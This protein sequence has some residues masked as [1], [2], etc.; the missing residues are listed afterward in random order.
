MAIK[1]NGQKA[2]L[3]GMREDV[4]A[5]EDF[6]S[7]FNQFLS[8][9]NY[10][11]SDFLGN[12][13][14]Y[15]SGVTQGWKAQDFIDF[16]EANGILQAIS[17]NGTTQI[18]A[19]TDLNKLKAIMGSMVIDQKGHFND[20]KYKL[21]SGEIAKLKQG[22][23]AYNAHN[24]LVANLRAKGGTDEQIQAVLDQQ[25]GTADGYSS[26]LSDIKDLSGNAWNTYVE[27]NFA[28]GNV[29]PDNTWGTGETSYTIS[30]AGLATSNADTPAETVSG[31]I[32]TA[33]VGDSS[34]AAVKQYAEDN[35]N[36]RFVEANGK[37]YLED[38]DDDGNPVA[39]SRQELAVD[40]DNN[41]IVYVGGDKQGQ[42]WTAPGD[43]MA[44]TYADMTDVE[45]ETFDKIQE[46]AGDYEQFVTDTQAAIDA[47]ANDFAGQINA[48]LNQ[49]LTGKDADGNPILGADKKPIKGFLDYQSDLEAAGRILK[50]DMQ[51]LQSMYDQAYSD[52]SGELDPL[53]N[54]MS[55]ITGQAMDVA[56]DAGDENYYGRLKDLYYQDAKEQIDRD[57]QG[58]RDTLTSTYAN[59][60][61]DPSSPAFTAAMTDLA[62]SRS[63]SLRSSRRQAILDSYGLGSQMLTNRSN[64]LNT[65]SGAV[66][67]EMNAVDSLYGVKLAG[68]N[69]RKDMI[70]QI[71][72]AARDVAGT[73]VTGLNTIL[74]AR[75]KG[76]QANQNQFNKNID[77]NNSL[78]SNLL[79][80]Y[81]GLRNTASTEADDAF[82]TL[83]EYDMGQGSNKL[84]LETLRQY[85]SE[86]PNYTID[87]DLEKFL[88]G[89]N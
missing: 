55:T 70:G 6:W 73:G 27:E 66:G 23:Q 1:Y 4:Q 39:N 41:Q 88:L 68:L 65:A 8:S 3:S 26:L 74:D 17:D 84:T 11:Q 77:L 52:Y 80:V 40:P 42:R 46:V 75:L 49:F 79:N 34:L 63:D 69:N 78:Y 14:S 58:A 53:R 60:G 2:I 48:Q 76:I 30:D 20:N 50:T 21:G 57:A 15:F 71:Y 29:L 38:L 59:A 35:D 24:E 62:K 16:F 22:I 86:N 5:P 51:G 54:K 67:A 72:G 37:Y 82:N 7:D 10:Y 13:N 19:R 64:A 44:S 18:N 32:D 9:D 45:R 31:Q 89:G 47:D 43:G 81:G 36:V 61:L 87:P 83:T 85:A 56:R 25:D 33:V 12:Y 28:K